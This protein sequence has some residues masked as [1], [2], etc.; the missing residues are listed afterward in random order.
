MTWRPRDPI[1]DD[2]EVSRYCQPSHY[3]HKRNEPT[4]LA[5]TRRKT[6]PDASANRLLYYRRRDANNREEAINLIRGELRPHLKLSPNGRF[7]VVNVG[8]FINAAASAGH[9]L[10]ILYTPEPGRPSHSSIFGV[11]MRP[12]DEMGA[13]VAVLRQYSP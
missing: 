9:L 7:L 8:T 5:F 11:P 3:D 12:D 10:E 13:A 2:E 1:P 6:E 4:A